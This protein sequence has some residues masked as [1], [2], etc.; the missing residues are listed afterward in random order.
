L[1][2]V[3]SRQPQ[4]APSIAASAAWCIDS[5]ASCIAAEEAH[6][7][8]S[9]EPYFQRL[10]ELLIA[11]T[12]RDDSNRANLRLSAFEA[13]NSLLKVCVFVCW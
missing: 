13:L 2:L 7:D 1:V 8:V 3:L 9:F 5:L 11:T 4:D 12:Q 10:A 6:S